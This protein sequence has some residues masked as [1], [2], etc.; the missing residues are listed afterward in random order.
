MGSDIDATRH[1]ICVT[2]T[3]STHRSYS[4]RNTFEYL[5]GEGRIACHGLG[6][7][8]NLAVPQVQVASI[9]DYWACTS[10]SIAILYKAIPD[11]CS[12]SLR[13]SVQLERDEITTL[14][15]C[16]VLSLGQGCTGR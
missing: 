15:R 10:H 16:S 12:R 5:I 13:N 6:I 1:R 2:A 7:G 8:A 14:I 4:S 9:I 11:A 3:S